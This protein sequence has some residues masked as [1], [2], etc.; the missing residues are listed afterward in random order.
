MQA[1]RLEQVTWLRRLRLFFASPWG[2]AAQAALAVPV[3]VFKL[4]IAGLVVFILLFSAL[5][6]LCDKLLTSA[7][8]FLLLC[9]FLVQSNPD[10]AFDR[11]VPFWWLVFFPAGAIIFHVVVYRTKFVRGRAFWAIL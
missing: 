4:Q 2:V 9:L 11:Y 3:I 10:G 1:L 8:P 6:A 5:M 7:V